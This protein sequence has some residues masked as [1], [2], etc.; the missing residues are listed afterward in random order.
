MQPP[1]S[2]P[3]PTTPRADYGRVTLPPQTFYSG[4][5]VQLPFGLSANLYFAAQ[6]GTPFNITTGTDLNGDTQYNDRPT[7]ATDLTRPSVVK[8]AFGNFD[9][10]PTAGQTVIPF[11]Y[12][13]S[14]SFVFLDLSLART[15]A[16]GP[17]P[18]A[19][20]AKPGAKPEPRPDPPYSLSF[21]VDAQNAF[22]HVNP[23]PPVGV[24]SSPLFGK[25][26]SLNSSLTSNTAANRVVTLQMSFQF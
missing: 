20:P 25:P 7:F 24:L 12:G 18:S 1:P 14:P 5:N 19:P 26:N 17:R 9:T 11:N 23:G 13:N 3:T 21:T 8:T 6:K 15:F 4:G 2:S 16:I 10:A 22:N